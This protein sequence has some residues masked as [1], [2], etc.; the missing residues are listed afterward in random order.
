MGPPCRRLGVP[1]LRLGHRPVLK[2]ARQ[3]LYRLDERLHLF[4]K[5][6][7]ALLKRGPAGGAGQWLRCCVHDP[8]AALLREGRPGPLV[9][10]VMPG[11][12]CPLAAR[13]GRVLV[14]CGLF[15]ALAS[16][17]GRFSSAGGRKDE[18]NHWAEWSAGVADCGVVE[19]GGGPG[20]LPGNEYFP[21]GGAHCCRPGLVEVVP[22]AVVAL[23]PQR[24]AGSGAVGDRG[25]VPARG[26]A[27]AL[28]GDGT[29]V[30]TVVLYG[31]VGICLLRLP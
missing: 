30:L 23:D 1:V 18:T 8:D 19:P 17:R 27:G 4:L 31:P 14:D 10:T 3:H 22:W 26:G 20:A 25:V 5:P 12:T 2:A 13:P 11:G 6:M 29:N 28:P 9:T 15:Q 24:G 21:P 7:Y 16:F